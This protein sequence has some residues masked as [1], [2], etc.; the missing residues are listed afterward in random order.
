MELKGWDEVK[1]PFKKGDRV[2]ETYFATDDEDKSPRTGI[3]IAIDKNSEGEQS[4]IAIQ[5]DVYHSR[6][7]D[8]NG[9]CEHGY[10]WWCPIEY[11]EHN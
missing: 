4:S 6:M 3:V 9:R 8:L 2:I 5:H 10:G 11:V 7:H 1:Q